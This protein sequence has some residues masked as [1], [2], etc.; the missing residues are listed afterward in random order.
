MSQNLQDAVVVTRLLGLRYLWIDSLC[1][2]QDSKSDWEE[3]GSKMD[4]VY[5]NAY[6]TLAATSATTSHDGFLQ[7]TP[8]PE[9]PITLAYYFKDHTLCHS[10]VYLAITDGTA[11]FLGFASACRTS[12]SSFPF[13][14]PFP[15]AGSLMQA[16]TLMLLQRSSSSA[17]TISQL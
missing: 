3:E 12:S 2:I 1:I 16:F 11:P 10:V 15:F 14:F 13:P 5:K 17:L 9:N 7:R 6:V 8:A 4:Q